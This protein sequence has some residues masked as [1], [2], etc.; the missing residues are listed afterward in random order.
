MNTKQLTL[1][2]RKSLI[3][4]S[5]GS[6]IRKVKSGNFSAVL[7]NQSSEDLSLIPSG[8]IDTI[9][10]SPPY[11]NLRNYEGGSDEVGLEKT[12]PEYVNTIVKFS[13][14]MK[15]VLK[16]TG[17]YF[18]N[19]GD[20]LRNG[21]KYLIPHR[22]AIALKEDGWILNDEIVWSKKNPIPTNHNRSIYSHEYIFHFVKTKEFE[23]YPQTK[24]NWG[25]ISVTS[26]TGRMGSIIHT[27]VATTLKLRNECLNQG[28]ELTN[29]AIFP[30]I[31]PEYLM[32][33]TTT[34]GDLILDPFN[35]SGTTASACKKMGRDYI[36][37]D[38]NPE[39][40]DAS[41]IRLQLAQ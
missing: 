21:E 20:T 41:I 27:S 25:D 13:R 16:G 4:K 23:Y 14:E 37:Y 30:S 31:L 9:I 29:T 15:R 8:I 12:I 26:G 3:I 7:V 11:F 19:L 39:Y 34:K 6:K 1:K 5:N 2:S 10:T 24:L 28:F 40:I 32:S 18:L 33:L 35:G 22:V 36:G 17:S 38:L